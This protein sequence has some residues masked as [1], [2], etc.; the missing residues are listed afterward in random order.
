MGDPPTFGKLANWGLHFIKKFAH[1]VYDNNP[2]LISRQPR[3]HRR[4]LST[5]EVN[6]VLFPEIDNGG[7]FS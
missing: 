4:H 6:T 1:P 7:N 5:Q 3:H 2:W